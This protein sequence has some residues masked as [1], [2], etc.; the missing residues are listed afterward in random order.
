LLTTQNIIDLNVEIDVFRSSILDRYRKIDRPIRMVMS[1]RMA[2]D[3]GDL[4]QLWR[5][6]IERLVR[7]RPHICASWLDADHRL[8]FTHAADIA[9]II[10]TRGRLA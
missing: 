6:G 8:V 3:H 1:T 7:E 2:G 5:A 4:N 9:R 10:R